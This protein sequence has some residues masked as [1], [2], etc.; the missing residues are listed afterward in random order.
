MSGF[1][2]NLLKSL[3]ETAIWFLEKH[4]QTQT[5]K[6]ITVH[7]LHKHRNLGYTLRSCNFAHDQKIQ[8]PNSCREVTKYITKFQELYPSMRRYDPSST[9][10]KAELYLNPN[11]VPSV[12]Y[13]LCNHLK[14]NWSS[15]GAG[16]KERANLGFRTRFPFIK[17]G[18]YL[19]LIC[20]KGIKVTKEQKGNTSQK[21]RLQHSGWLESLWRQTSE[22]TSP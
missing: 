4:L 15:S 7:I 12:A 13:W 6:I 10:Y 5:L 21:F 8:S 3:V 22:E 19:F 9:G 2:I 20:L 14:G 16:L 1:R 17:M 11:L 18:L